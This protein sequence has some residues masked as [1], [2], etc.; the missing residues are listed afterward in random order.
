MATEHFVTRPPV[1]DLFRWTSE[2]T[3]TTAREYFSRARLGDQCYDWCTLSI[4]GGELVI[5]F[6]DA[7]WENPVV[8]RVP[9]GSY[10]VHSSYF[11]VDV[12]TA[13]TVSERWFPAAEAPGAVVPG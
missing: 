7:S 6:S 2:D 11:Y 5:T 8:Y 13:A 3:L 10:A 9:V 12:L 1:Q 4:D